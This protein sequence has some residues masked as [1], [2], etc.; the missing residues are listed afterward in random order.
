MKSILFFLILQSFY[1]F[2]GMSDASQI[3]LIIL[4]FAVVIFATAYIGVVI[5]ERR[6]KQKLIDALLNTN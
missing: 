6:N 2:L 3:S 1:F 5:K 4:G